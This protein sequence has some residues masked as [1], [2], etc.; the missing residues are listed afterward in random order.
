MDTHNINLGSRRVEIGFRHNTEE[1]LHLFKHQD[2][3]HEIERHIETAAKHGEAHFFIG[4]NRYKVTH[5]MEGG[6]E[7]IS[8]ERSHH[9]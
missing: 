2:S 6:K 5:N 7:V 9:H 1:A 3:K 8:V 4:D